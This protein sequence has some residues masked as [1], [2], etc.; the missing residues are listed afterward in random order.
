MNKY[1][2]LA[3]CSQRS[4]FILNRNR[5]YAAPVASQDFRAAPPVNP[6]AVSTSKVRVVPASPSY[7]TSIPKYTDDL[8]SLE[9]LLRKYQTLPVLPSDQGPRVTWKT[10]EQYR[11]ELAEPVREKPYNMLLELLKRLNSIHPSLM[12][13]EVQQTLES[14][15]R[16]V[17][18]N[19]SLARPRTVDAYG[20][21]RAN[22]R[23]KSS[24]AIAY[25]VEGYGEVLINDRSIVDYFPRLHDRESA[26]WPLKASMRLDKYNTC[27]VVRGGGTTGQAEAITLAIAKSLLI[28]EPDLKPVLRRAGCITRNYKTVERKK[29]GKRKARKMPQWVKR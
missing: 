15:K 7:F 18:P 2:A 1:R 17:Q 8:L 28:H 14:Y 3:K 16:A 4:S 22:G 6:N 5:A 10:L 9:K 27:I 29:P 24:T 11:T 21:S 12:P 19:L 25:L 23:R 20:V 26:L 13:E